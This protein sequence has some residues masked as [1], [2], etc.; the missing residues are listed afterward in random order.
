M[1]KLLSAF[2]TCILACFVLLG[3]YM[4]YLIIHA[5]LLVGV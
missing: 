1:S 5:L 3:A 2:I 4:V